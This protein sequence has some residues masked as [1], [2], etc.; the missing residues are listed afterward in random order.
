[1]MKLPF[2]VF[3]FVSEISQA[4]GTAE[5]VADMILG[6]SPVVDCTPFSIRGRF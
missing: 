2:F 5:M 4:L 6:N 3:V 1:M